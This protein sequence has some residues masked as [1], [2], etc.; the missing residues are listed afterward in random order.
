VPELKN[1]I[2]T[3]SKKE[4]HNLLANYKKIGKNINDGIDR[5]ALTMGDKEGRD[6]FIKLLKENNFEVKIDNIGNIFGLITFNKENEFI[7]SGSH[8]DSQPNGG[9]FDGILGVLNAFTAI[10]ELANTFKRE[11]LRSKYNLAVVSWTNEEGARFQPSILGSSVYSGKIDIND[12]YK[13]IDSNRISVKDSLLE[14]NYFGKDNFDKPAKYI[15]THVECGRILENNENQIGIINNYWGCHKH[16]IYL[17]GEQSHTGPTPMSQRKD[18]LHAASLIIT[19]LKNMSDSSKKTLHTSVG[20]IDVYPNSPNVVPGF[21][22]LFSEIRSPYED[23][24]KENFI[25]FENF[26]QKVS[27]NTG[28]KIKIN[29]HS[30]RDAG[31]FD[32]SINL[33]IESILKKNQIRY[34]YLDTIAAHDAVPLSKIVP[35]TV[36]VTPSVNGIIHDPKEYTKPEDLEICLDIL[37][38]YLYDECAKDEQ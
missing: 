23:T 31:K 21:V 6:Y 36:F 15:E 34:Q 2:S 11:G 25:H 20:K 32:E 29:S 18:A 19:E 28:I 24:L 3:Q 7:L 27:H 4:L 22:S 30:K 37:Y 35:S 13:I 9:N 26:I 38:Q 17:T 14:I 12:A 10:K 16:N 8:I 1:Q 5:V 33:K